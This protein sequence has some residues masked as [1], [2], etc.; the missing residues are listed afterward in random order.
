MTR[1]RLLLS[2]EVARMDSFFLD[3]LFRDFF[4]GFT[5]AS[6]RSVSGRAS[7]IVAGPGKELTGVVTRLPDPAP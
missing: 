2:C 4:V 7:G 5:L 1:S 6:N 3:V